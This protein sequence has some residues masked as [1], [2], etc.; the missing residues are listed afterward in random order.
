MIQKK[1]EQ[2]HGYYGNKGSSYGTQLIFPHLK[3]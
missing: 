1:E 3:Y 2:I